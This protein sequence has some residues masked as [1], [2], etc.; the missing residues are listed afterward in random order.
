MRFALITVVTLT[1]VGCAE[2]VAEPLPT[3]P[4]PFVA[5]TP[6]PP[7]N[8]PVPTAPAPP[9]L[10]F[11]WVVVTSDTG[12]GLCIP[13]ARVEI[14]GGQGL[15]RGLTQSTLGCSY[16]DPDYDAI[17]KGLNVGEELTLRASA[18]GYAAKETTVVPTPGGQSAVSIVLSRIQ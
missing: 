17:F 8:P 5:T 2:N 18:P 9:A 15:G 13:G 16:W 12:G 1:L 3:A 10:T 14:V 6:S 7:P 4:T 11:V